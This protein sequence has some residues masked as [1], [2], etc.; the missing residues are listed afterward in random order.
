MINTRRFTITVAT[1][2]ILL[3]GCRPRIDTQQFILEQN[4]LFLEK[5]GRIH[6]EKRSNISDAQKALHFL[7]LAYDLDISNL[8]LGILYSHTCYFNGRYIVADQ[9]EKE[10]LFS[11]GAAATKTA[12]LNAPS[13]SAAYNKAVGDSTAKFIQ[14]VEAM[15]DTLLPAL[16]W[17]MVN[18]GSILINQPVVERIKNRVMIE[19]VLHKLLIMNPTFYYGGPYRLLGVFYARIPGVE[20]RQSK[21]YFDQAISSYPGYLST[22]TLLSQFY[23]TKSGEQEH[24]RSNLESVISSDPSQIPEVMPENL[25]EQEIARSL[26][27]QESLLFE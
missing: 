16:Y 10:A 17:W 23:H 14:A 5:Q 3:S 2:I 1:F 4:A 7:S 19:S 24:F 18:T 8:E 12:L 9:A 27:S 15:E 6:W 26:L 25:F 11:H 21:S 22:K 20:L 13:F